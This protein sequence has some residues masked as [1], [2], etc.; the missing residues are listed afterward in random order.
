VIGLIV[1]ILSDLK[2]IS[3]GPELPGLPYPPPSGAKHPEDVEEIPFAIQ[4]STFD[5][6]SQL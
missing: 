6:N 3:T 2:G 5:G 1:D 4:D